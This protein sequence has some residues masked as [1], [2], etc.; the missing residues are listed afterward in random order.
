MESWFKIV[1]HLSPWFHGVHNQIMNWATDNHNCNTTVDTH[2]NAIIITLLLITAICQLKINTSWN[3]NKSMYSPCSIRA[4]WR[5]RFT[6]RSMKETPIN[7]PIRWIKYHIVTNY[8]T[9]LLSSTDSNVS[10]QI[11]NLATEE[12]IILLLI[13]ATRR[14]RTWYI[15]PYVRICIT[16]MTEKKRLLKM[17]DNTCNRKKNSSTQHPQAYPK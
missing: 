16:V 8:V 3:H 12:I 15:K 10:F 17:L 1:V 11:M 4:G 13:C 7:C 2:A 9:L 5:S 6:V 14:G